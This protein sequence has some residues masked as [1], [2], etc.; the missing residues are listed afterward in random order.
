MEWT[1]CWIILAT[2]QGLGIVKLLP[3]PRLTHCQILSRILKT[4]KIMT[5]MTQTLKQAQLK[6]VEETGAR[7][8]SGA[9]TGTEIENWKIEIE[10]RR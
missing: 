7:G 10:N 4:K 5:R 3:Q 8:D 9:G 6:E 2:N 1:K